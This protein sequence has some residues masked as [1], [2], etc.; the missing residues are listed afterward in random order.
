[1]LKKHNPIILHRILDTTDKNIE[2]KDLMFEDLRKPAMASHNYNAN[3]TNCSTL[4]TAQLFIRRK[5]PRNG[6]F[7]CMLSEMNT[8]INS[9]HF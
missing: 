9:K 5:R 1:M 8:K 6:F 7:K 3:C 2:N 4:V